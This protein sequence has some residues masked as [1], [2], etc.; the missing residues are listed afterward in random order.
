MDSYPKLS[1]GAY[2][3]EAMLKPIFSR[4]PPA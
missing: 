2:S 1:V 4:H 3:V